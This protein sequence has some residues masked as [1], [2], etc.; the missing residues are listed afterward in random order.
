VANLDVKYMDLKAADGGDGGDADPAPVTP[1]GN[2][3]LEACPCDQ[4]Q[5]LACC[6]SSKGPAF[7]TTDQGRCDSEQGAFYRR[8]GPDRSRDRFCC[9][10]GAGAG[11]MT[12][13]AA[14]CKERPTACLKDTHCLGGATCHVRKCAGVEIGACGQDAPACPPGTGS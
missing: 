14:E 4:S 7:C 1:A 5:G 11:A 3:E 10:T 12:A 9:W 8:F 6:V 2:N 13:Y